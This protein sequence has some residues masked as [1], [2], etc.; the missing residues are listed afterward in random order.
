VVQVEHVPAESEV[1]L[2]ASLP[3]IDVQAGLNRMLGRRIG[4]FVETAYMYCRMKSIEG[5]GRE[6]RIGTPGE[7]SWE[8]IWGIKREEIHVRWG[9]AEVLVPTNYWGGWIE[10]Q[11]ERDFVLD[12]SG[13]RLVLGICFRL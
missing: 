5:S 4:L 1:E 2:P 12:L 3:G 6:T 9:D 10:S 7:A 11:R 8:G 13:F